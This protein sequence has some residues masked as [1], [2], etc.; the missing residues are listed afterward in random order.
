MAR[1]WLR[2]EP[3][4]VP[5]DAVADSEKLKTLKELGTFYFRVKFFRV[6]GGGDK[7]FTLKGSAPET[8]HCDSGGS[9]IAETSLS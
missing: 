7:E 4:S 6:N 5:S 1:R 9:L 3:A 2:Y 8:F